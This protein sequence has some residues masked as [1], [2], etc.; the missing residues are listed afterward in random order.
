MS[1][2]IVRGDVFLTRAQAVAV[3]L[4]AAGRMEV[5]PLF[6][7]LRD[8]YPVFVSEFHRRGRVGALTPGEL[9]VWP[10]SQPWLVGMVV[11][12][13]PQGA[14]RLRYVEAVLHALLHNGDYTGIHSLAIAPLADEVEWPAVR[15]LIARYLASATLPVVV[16][17]EY[18]P[19]TTAD[20]SLLDA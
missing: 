9:W 19:G 7:A 4:N 5:S 3:G 14:T 2:T 18:S 13:T 11:R 8:R 12:E 15:D 6:T 17:D 16:Y 1:V 20:E 10:D